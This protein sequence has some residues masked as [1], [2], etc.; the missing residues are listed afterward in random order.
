M[1]GQVHGIPKQRRK[2]QSRRPPKARVHPQCPSATTT[3][4]RSPHSP[5]RALTPLTAARLANH[6][7]NSGCTKAWIKVHN[8]LEYPRGYSS[9]YIRHSRSLNDTAVDI[10]DM[11]RSQEHRT[12][13]PNIGS[14]VKL[15]ALPTWQAAKSVRG[16]HT[17]RW[18]QQS[19]SRGACTGTP[20]QGC[21]Y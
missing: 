4:S 20:G 2:C 18:T 17:Q 5:P 9:E 10:Y 1:G 16:H 8:L 6:A 19:S 15:V 7:S 14:R 12:V 3:P 13:N 11:I 21:P